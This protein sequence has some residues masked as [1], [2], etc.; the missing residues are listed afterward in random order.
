MGRRSLIVAALCAFL[1]VLPAMAAE[2][3]KR[4][5]IKGA[6]LDLLEDLRD[7]AEQ[8][9][10]IRGAGFARSPIGV[11]AGKAARDAVADF[12]A[13]T[14]ISAARLEAR[15][16]AWVD[17]GLGDDEGPRRLLDALARGVPG[18]TV[19]VAK[20]RLLVDPSIF[21]EEDP[22]EPDE[23]S[24]TLL[25]ATGV[26][27]DEP[28]MIHGLMQLLLLEEGQP[29][30]LRPTT[31]GLLAGSSWTMG[32]SN[33]A[34]M[35]YL[36]A[37]MGL[38]G[39]VVER[40]LRPSNVL[41][42]RLEPNFSELPPVSARL[43]EFSYGEGYYQAA[44]TFKGG[45]WKAV[46]EAARTR[47]STWAVLNPGGESFSACEVDP[48][49]GKLDGFHQA[50]RDVLGAHAVSVLIA[51]LSGK[52]NLG[53][54]AADGWR[55]DE[56]TRWELPGSPENGITTWDTY[57]RDA[58]AAEDFIYGYRR[59]LERRFGGK[60]EKGPD[61]ALKWVHDGREYSLTP[62]GD[63]V[64]VMIRPAPADPA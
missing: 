39:E 55:C 9:K 60:G 32:Q 8:M 29:D 22:A 27:P 14:V 47:R 3:P 21:P 41:D 44:Q 50:D 61:G 56:L 28:L 5:A 24:D 13:G 33:L 45:G 19:D 59:G 35:L 64:R 26:R 52:D 7:L 12:R 51:E 31:D 25:L 18:F 30:P 42:G 48:E 16:R 62:A 63:Q 11:R 46:N 10:K 23:V 38:T 57:W 34:A 6:D 53:L 20:R 40:G 43:L 54:I 37:A 15:G 49:A 1:A 58:Q 17:L 2:A 4:P 36:F